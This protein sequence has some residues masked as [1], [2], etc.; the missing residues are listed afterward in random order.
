MGRLTA[1][2]G[3]KDKTFSSNKVL[4]K[5]YCLYVMENDIK[6]L[7]KCRKVVQKLNYM[8]SREDKN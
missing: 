1:E 4:V 8:R 5:K 2:R 6:V 3:Q 7:F